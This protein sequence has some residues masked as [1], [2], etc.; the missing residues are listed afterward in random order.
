MLLFLAACKTEFRKTIEKYPNGK[1]S[2]EYVYPDKRDTKKFTYVAY[3][4]NGDT[5]FIQNR[6]QKY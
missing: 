4:E 6:H 2:I 3:Y 5:M 1:V